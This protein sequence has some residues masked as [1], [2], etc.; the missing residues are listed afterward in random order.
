[1]NLGIEF[2]Y[3][4]HAY[5]RAGYQSGFDNKSFSFGIGVAFV[6]VRVDYAFTPF[7]NDFGTSHA[8]SISVTP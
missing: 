4:Q 1:M 6:P 8:F 2:A 3:Q 5:V 7:T